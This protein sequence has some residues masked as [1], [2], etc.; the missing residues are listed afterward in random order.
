MH[1]ARRGLHVEATKQGEATSFDVLQD[2]GV[3]MRERIFRRLTM[4]AP[5]SEFASALRRVPGMVRPLEVHASPERLVF[6]A[7][8][9]ARR[10][11]PPAP[12]ITEAQSS[13]LLMPPTPGFAFVPPGFKVA[14]KK[15]S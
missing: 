8:D 2:L 13:R 5:L 3:A 6:T 1:V 15:R 4:R 10:S 12:H 14:P 7:S 11:N 9:A